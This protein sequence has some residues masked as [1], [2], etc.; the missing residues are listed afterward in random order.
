[1]KF[2][3]IIIRYGEIALKGKETRNRFENV[4]VSNIKNA[5]QTEK[6]VHKI[7]KERGRIYV[8]T[9]EIQKSI[10][11]L[12]KLFGITS[13]SPAAQVKSDM[14]SMS[15]FA[16]KIAKENKL[17]EKTSFALRVTRTGNQNYSSQDVAVKLG[18]DIVNATAAKVDLTNP[19]FKLFIEIRQKEA[20]FFVEKIRGIGGMPLNTQGKVLCLVDNCNSIFAAWYLMRRGCKVVFTCLDESY[21]DAIE[22]FSKEWYASSD[23]VLVDSKKEDFYKTL[24]KIGVE[25]NCDAIVTGFVFDDI[26]KIKTITEK[27]NVPVLHPLIAMEKDEIKNKCKEIRLKI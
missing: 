8:F 17:T 25:N 23:I 1:V 15:N 11:V 5:L 16:V 4:L 27:C 18:N 2:E 10:S 22:N 13:V 6:I 19:F 20:F 12:Q 26:S 9:D 3:L 24:N 7:K 14:D 21:C